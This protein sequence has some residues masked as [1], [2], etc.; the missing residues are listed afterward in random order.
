MAAIRAGRTKRVRG[1][2]DSA[3]RGFSG[4]LVLFLTA[5]AWALN[6]SAVKYA[7][8][9]GFRPLAFAAPRYA[10]A[11]VIFASAGYAREGRL[12]PRRGDLRLV[13][14]AALFGIVFDQ[15]SFI[16]GLHFAP[17]AVVALVFGAGPVI[18]A[19]VASLAHV[20]RLTRRSWL[21]AVISTVG[22][23]L[24]ALGS[25]AAINGDLGGILLAL[26]ATVSWACYSVAI[27]P[28]LRRYS[29]LRVN[30]LVNLIG[31]VPIAIAAIPTLSQQPWSAITPVAWAAWT[32]SLIVSYL[33]GS[34]TWMMGV[35]RVGASRASLYNNAQPFLGALFAVFILSEHLS[36]LQALGGAVV[37]SGIVIGLRKRG[38]RSSSG[39]APSVN[40]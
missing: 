28:L 40:E 37:A 24:V 39:A 18:T 16:F 15:V 21:A 38:L 23:A 11:G 13:A 33:L 1:V 7:L 36:S 9:H 22:V 10:L 12:R 2:A 35:R 4:D 25:P 19:V 26:G 32:Y 14:V 8:G 17:A 5:A 31:G 3:H 27:M 20:E 6:I 34:V 30:A 29:T